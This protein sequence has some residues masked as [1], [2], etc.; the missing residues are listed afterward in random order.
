MT[1]LIQLQKRSNKLS[2][3]TNI[4]K[5]ERRFKSKFIKVK[6]KLKKLNFIK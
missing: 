3:K 6:I 2:L 5:L 1:I 4:N